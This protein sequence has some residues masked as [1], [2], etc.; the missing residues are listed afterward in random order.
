MLAQVEGVGQAGRGALEFERPGEKKPRRS[1]AEGS[2]LS[3]PEGDLGD[4][5]PYASSPATATASLP[6][7]G[8]PSAVGKSGHGLYLRIQSGSGLGMPSRRQTSTHKAAPCVSSEDS[9]KSTGCIKDGDRCD[10]HHCHGEHYVS[11]SVG[12]CEHVQHDALPL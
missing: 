5:K 10:C 8:F 11:V 6:Q 12:S 9:W 7:S 3:G 1:G 2:Y 4:I